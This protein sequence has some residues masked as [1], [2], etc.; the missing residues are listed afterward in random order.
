MS[1]A[2]TCL[3]NYS[4]SSDRQECIGKKSII[5][6]RIAQTTFKFL[7]ADASQTDEFS[8]C[9][10]SPCSE[11]STC[12]DLPSETF[13]CICLPE[14][15]GAL[16]DTEM[17]YKQYEVPAFDGRSYV[18]LK[19]LKA[20]HKLSLELEFKAY[21]EDGIIMY[22]QQKSNGMGD[23]FSLALVKGFVEFRYNLG[24]GAAVIKSLEKIELKRFHRLVIKRYHRDGLLKLDDGE[25]VR[26]ESPGTLKALDL[27]EDTF[28]GYVPTNHSKVFENIGTKNGFRGCIR[29]LNIG[30]RELKFRED[31]I[32][33]FEGVHECG[34]SPCV[35]VPCKNEGTC[36]AIDLVVFRCHCTIHYTGDY[37]ET[38]LD[39]C[40]SNPCKLGTQCESIGPGRSLC[41]CPPG[42]KG[43][44]CE[45]LE[46]ATELL[47]PEFNG[48]SF[49]QLPRLDGIGRTFSI[50]IVFL[51]KAHNGI[52]LYSGQLRNGKGDFIS[53]N[54]IHGHLQFRFNLG[55][56]I[57][58]M[59]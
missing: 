11:G 33:H 30:R 39:P 48:S 31:N 40:H 25:D 8:A 29:K 1:G 21:S 47:S 41:K 20:Y 14:F 23:F 51:P 34:E 50:D 10:S 13:T 18:R 58:N 5:K 16:C 56:G 36:E 27:E 45:L 7:T 2:C 49:L 32:I 46:N 43:E 17:M 53:L 55:S 6:F 59:T 3:P 4:E 22:N 12:I 57:A 54:L 19:A 35:S 28:V 44:S 52:L 26:G 42:R 38:A 24:N 37:C 15:T 9:S